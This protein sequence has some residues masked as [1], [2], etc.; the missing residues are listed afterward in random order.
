MRSSIP[1]QFIPD[2]RSRIM[3]CLAI[4]TFAVSLPPREAA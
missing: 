4:G 1:E 2:K 3:R